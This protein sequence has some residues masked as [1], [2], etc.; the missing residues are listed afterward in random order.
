MNTSKDNIPTYSKVRGK[1][2]GQIVTGIYKDEPKRLCLD[3]EGSI[4]WELIE[5]PVVVYE[6]KLPI[7]EIPEGGMVDLTNGVSVEWGRYSQYKTKQEAM[8]LAEAIASLCAGID[9]SMAELGKAMQG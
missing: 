6:P 8:A 2:N 3:S 5:E 7:H 9:I 4:R 1:Y